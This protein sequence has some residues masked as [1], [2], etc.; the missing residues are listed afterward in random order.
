[1]TETEIGSVTHY[2][3]HIGVAVL[4]L[5]GTISVGDKVRFHGH[6]SD[7]EQDV[8]SLQIEHKEVSSA[9]KGDDVAIKVTERVHEH[10]EVYKI[11]P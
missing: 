5:T 1:M 11:T 7:F 3:H 4:A 2:F 8:T 9:K 6:T 10:D